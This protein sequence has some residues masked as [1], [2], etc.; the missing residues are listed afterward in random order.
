[1]KVRRKCKRGNVPIDATFDEILC[2]NKDVLHRLK[3][4][5]YEYPVTVKD[6]VKWLNE[7]PADAKIVYG[8]DMRHIIKKNDLFLDKERNWLVLSF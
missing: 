5:D 4:D 2:A 1:M 6:F 3:T 7:Y 8:C